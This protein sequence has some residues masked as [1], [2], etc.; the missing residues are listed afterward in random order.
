MNVCMLTCVHMYACVCLC[1]CN[2]AGPA[3]DITAVALY[4]KNFL[5]I[6]ITL[7]CSDDAANKNACLSTIQVSIG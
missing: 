7:Y 2:I 4:A 1:V 3:E 5:P 6:L